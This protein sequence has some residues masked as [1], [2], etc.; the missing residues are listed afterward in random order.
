MSNNLKF[1]HGRP[2]KCLQASWT[3]DFPKAVASKS[4]RSLRHRIGN[5]LF[6]RALS[7]LPKCQRTPWKQH[8]SYWNC[9]AKQ[10]RQWSSAHEK[11][12]QLLPRKPTGKIIIN[13]LLLHNILDVPNNVAHVK[14]ERERNHGTLAILTGYTE[15]WRP[16]LL[17]SSSERST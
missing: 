12:G 14:K 8:K 3:L 10:E 5:L 15:N 17:T 2:E 7:N 6:K 1:G 11:S 16:V 13:K 4:L 9:G